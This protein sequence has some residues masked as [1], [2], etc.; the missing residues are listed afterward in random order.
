MATISARPTI[1]AA[2][3]QDRERSGRPGAHLQRAPSDI[4]GLRLKQAILYSFNGVDDGINGRTCS[5]RPDPAE[6]FGV[7]SLSQRQFRRHLRPGRPGRPRRR[8][9]LGFNIGLTDP[10]SSTSRSPT[11]T[12]SATR[13]WTGASCGRAG[14]G[15]PVLAGLGHGVPGASGT[16]GSSCRE[17]I[18]MATNRASRPRNGS[19]CSRRRWWPG[20]R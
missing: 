11:T 1:S 12:S 16:P 13:T 18:T 14:S 20:W 15:L 5:P 2:R 8:P 17:V 6:P 3:T 19:S 7:P 10:S 9:E 4:L